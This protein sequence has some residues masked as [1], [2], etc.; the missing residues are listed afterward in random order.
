MRA[1]FAIAIAGCSGSQT[2]CERTGVCVTVEAGGTQISAPSPLVVGKRFQPP[3]ANTAAISSSFGPRWKT[4]ASRDDFHLGIDYFGEPGTPLLAIGDGVVA[5][6]YPDGNAT[7][8]NGGNVVV[9][10]HPIPETTFHGRPVHRVFAVYLHAQSFAVAPGDVVTAGQT[11]ATMGMTGDAELTH[12]HF[13][14]RVETQC[15]QLSP[16]GAGFDPHVHPFLFV[17][18][19]DDDAIQVEPLPGDG[20]GVRFIEHRGDLDL[21]VIASDLGTLGFDERR[22]VDMQH[23]DSFDY[24]WLRLVAVPFSSTSTDRV[25]ELHF[26]DRPSWLELRDIYGRGL[27]F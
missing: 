21:D 23:L 22:G 8:P 13:E 24:G 1:L 18:S 25:F 9:I 15:S 6:V 20:F 19:P 17:D 11:V 7:F 2:E 26:A 27:R 10:E 12:L 5:G 3:V 4:S 16:C 14:T